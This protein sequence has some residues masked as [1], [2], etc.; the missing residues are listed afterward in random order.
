MDHWFLIRGLVREAAHWGAFLPAF[1]AALPD[2]EVHCL[3]IPGNGR[4]HRRPTPLTVPGIMEV[5]RAEARR[6]TAEPAYLFALSLG[7]MVALEW[8]HQHPG[9]LAGI[10]LGNTS[11][12]GFSPFY[13]RMRPQAWLPVLRSS[14]ARD[15]VDKQR[16]ILSVISSRTEVHDA[17]A[18]DWAEV[19]R[20]RPVA[21]KNAFRQIVA[22]SRYRPPA[23]AP[24]VPHLILC[25]LGDRLVDPDCSHAI[26]RGWNGRLEAHPTAGHDL[27]LD[28]GPWVIDRIR[29][30]RR[31]LGG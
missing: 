6:V 11:F 7:G 14:M 31:G 18:N 20:L 19:D 24:R 8:A 3:D 26:Q 9:E 2:A 4:H 25:G 16:A 15:P 30:W 29:E 22:A 13:R 10:V 5:M 17:T 27:T 21:P 1:S 28:A 23:T 12:G